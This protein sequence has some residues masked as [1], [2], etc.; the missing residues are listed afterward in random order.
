[1]LK[2]RWRAA[3]TGSSPAWS[4][5]VHRHRRVHGE[6]AGVAWWVGFTGPPWTGYE[7]VWIG[8]NLDHSTKIGRLRSKGEDGVIG[9]A[10]A[11]GGAMAGSSAPHRGF[12]R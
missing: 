8:S 1:M 10:L 6:P 4:H 3:L 2:V 5:M 9:A 7:G 12:S 11:D